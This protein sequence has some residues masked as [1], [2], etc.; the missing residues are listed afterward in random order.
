M[1]Q[2][3]SH[4]R[5][6]ETVYDT[7]PV[8][9]KYHYASRSLDKLV[10]VFH[11]GAHQ[12]KQLSRNTGRN[13]LSHFFPSRIAIRVKAK[14]RTAFPRLDKGWRKR[15]ILHYPVQHKLL[16][17]RPVITHP[18]LHVLDLSIN[19]NPFR[20]TTTSSSISRQFIEML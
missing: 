18:N 15:S 6:A 7:R 9:R 11:H 2:F 4:I 8:I 16:P 12:G 3:D 13:W 20:G 19:G 10:H 17:D 5:I 1:F 14:R